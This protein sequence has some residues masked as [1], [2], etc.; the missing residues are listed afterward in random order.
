MFPISTA[1]V[2]EL[3]KFAVQSLEMKDR[4]LMDSIFLLFQ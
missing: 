2:S 1:V 3:T 4:T